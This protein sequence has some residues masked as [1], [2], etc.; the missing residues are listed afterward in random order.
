MLAGFRLRSTSLFQEKGE[1]CTD[2]IISS[3]APR[4]RCT[5]STRPCGPSTS[6]IYR[7]GRRRG[8]SAIRSM[9]LT[10]FAAISPGI[11]AWR[12]SSSSGIRS[13]GAE[14][15]G[16]G[17]SSGHVWWSFGRSS[18]RC[19]TSRSSY[20][21]RGMGCTSHP[22]SESSSAK[23]SA[24]SPDDWRKNVG[25][26]RLLGEE[27]ANAREVWKRVPPAVPGRFLARL[28]RIAKQ[29]KNGLPKETPR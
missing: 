4:F 28:M 24:V 5:A 8:A 9:A 22:S 19:W 26:S 14:L 3:C 6:I 17:R 15:P 16:R 13:R 23:D 29:R 18:G 27:A 7:L 25:A 21:E 1:T 10:P 2:S 12:S 11:G 20:G